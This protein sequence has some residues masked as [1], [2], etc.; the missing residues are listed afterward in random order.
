MATDRRVFVGKAVAAGVA[1]SAPMIVS[2]VALADSGTLKCRASLT[3]L[4]IALSTVAFTSTGAET[5]PRT[6]AIITG[7]P[8]ACPCRAPA[9][10]VS[11]RWNLT[12]G[13]S[14]TPAPRLTRAGAAY[15]SALEPS[16]AATRQIDVSNDP[17]AG[18]DDLEVSG[19]YTLTATV[20]LRCN[21]VGATQADACAS[22]T[23]TFVW[24]ASG[25]TDVIVGTPTQGTIQRSIAC[26]P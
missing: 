22:R 20:R 13:P 15:V 21:G 18:S 17:T 24:D 10:A 2:S 26:G 11:I 14:G 23:I 19:A 16:S 7:V 4:N 12:S 6:T 25:T 8:A 1:W 5:V 3:G 9:P